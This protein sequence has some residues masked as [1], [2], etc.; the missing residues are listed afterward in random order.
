MTKAV[1][2]LNRKAAMVAVP[3]TALV[4]MPSAAFAQ[5]ATLS[6]QITAHQ[7]EAVAT[8]GQLGGYVIAVVGAIALIGIVALLLKRR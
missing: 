3:A 5:A 4:A 2:F 7:G 8:T 6:E 1:K